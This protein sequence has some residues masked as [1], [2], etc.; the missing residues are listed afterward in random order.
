[1]RIKTIGTLSLVMLLICACLP[2]DTCAEERPPLSEEAVSLKYNLKVGDL[3]IYQAKNSSYIISGAGMPG[4]RRIDVEGTHTQVVTKVSKDAAY[5]LVIADISEITRP[6]TSVTNM[7]TEHQRMLP[8]GR[9]IESSALAKGPL[10]TL[11]FS[12]GE[13]PSMPV[14]KGETWKTGSESP[15]GS[16]LD[17]QWTLIGFQKVK[18]YD[19]AQLEGTFTGELG[20]L[21][22]THSFAVKEGF[23]IAQKVEV[24]MKSIPEEPKDFEA[25]IN[26]AKKL[27]LP[28]PEA[29]EVDERNKQLLV[30]ELIKQLK[31]SDVDVRIE[32]ARR[33]A[34][35]GI[36]GRNL[37]SSH[38]KRAVESL[39]A[40]LKD[41][42]IDVRAAAAEA[43]GQIGDKR[44]VEKLIDTLKDKDPDVRMSAANA[45][46]ILGDKQ[47]ISQLEW[48]TKEDNIASVRD[49][50]QRALKQLRPPEVK[51]EVQS[52]SGTISLE[53]ELMKKEEL[54]STKLEETVSALELAASGQDELREQNSD[55][56]DGK[57]PKQ[58][59]KD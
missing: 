37:G 31:D 25:V 1:M 3:F 19:C 23:T 38:G 55:K 18:G 6:F 43:L 29:L 59:M 57:Q 50:A 53:L 8:D 22:L 54:P 45:L 58:I 11:L 32:A 47:A 34:A 56:A 27:P 33:L 30:D 42:D 2:M 46:G 7:R 41:R 5:S 52:I 15:R 36:A 35:V 48:V 51:G 26:Q 13:L 16:S 14:K 20:K 12:A 9:I 49:A 21:K 4:V 10:V 17:I 39:I 24:K 40:A 44:A 28:S